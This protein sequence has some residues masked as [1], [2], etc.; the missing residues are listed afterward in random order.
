MSTLVAAPSLDSTI[1]AIEIGVLLSFILFGATV[2]QLY[3]YYQSNFVNDSRALKNLLTLYSFLEC[4]HTAFIGAY[5]YISTITNFGNYEKLEIAHWT[6]GF[7]IPVANLVMVL[8]QGFFAYRIYC[9]CRKWPITIISWFGQF[10]RLVVALAIAI[11]SHIMKN[12]PLFISRY[13]WLV[14]LS[15]VIGAAIDIVNTAA[16]GYFLYRAKT[17]IQR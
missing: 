4:V 10:L 15:L 1:G 14:I 2:V 13:R 3:I 17:Q 12:L 6:L 5:I 8:V 11:I 16:L 9:L 7:S